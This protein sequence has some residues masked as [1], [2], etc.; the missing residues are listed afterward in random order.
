[1]RIHPLSGERRFHEGIDIGNNQL[2]D[3]VSTASGTIKFAGEKGG[4]GHTVIVDHG[5]GYETL[6][7]HNEHLLVEEGD[8]V[9]R[10]TVIARM[11]SSGRSTG[12]HLHYEVRVNREIV[13][14]ALFI[15]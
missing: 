6:Y 11:G 5:M 7:A 2:T 9:D 4:D 12:P 13:D 8:H 3:I 10:G 1:M 15:Y 14:P